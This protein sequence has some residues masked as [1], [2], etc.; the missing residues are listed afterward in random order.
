M[1][2]A[3]ADTLL[4]GKGG[5]TLKGGKGTDTLFGGLGQDWLDGGSGNDVLHGGDAF[6][7]RPHVSAVSLIL[8]PATLILAVT[9]PHRTSRQNAAPF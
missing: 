1:G 5:D 8:A 2:F 6:R 9:Y 3:G 7:M 4:G